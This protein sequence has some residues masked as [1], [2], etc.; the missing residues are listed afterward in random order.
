[1]AAYIGGV[2]EYSRHVRATVE[3]IGWLCL[4]LFSQDVLGLYNWTNW[5]VFA[6]GTGLILAGLVEGISA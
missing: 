4:V 3:G 2:T 6:L 1:M 5:L